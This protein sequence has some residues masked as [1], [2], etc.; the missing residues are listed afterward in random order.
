[1]KEKAEKVK[2]GKPGKPV[3]TMRRSNDVSK[4]CVGRR[5][6]GNVSKLYRG[7]ISGC[8][9]HVRVFEDGHLSGQEGNSRLALV[10]SQC[11]PSSIG[12]LITRR[13]HMGVC[14]DRDEWIDASGDSW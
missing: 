13:V 4:G 10:E 14:N 7:R 1:V 9:V 11:E 3:A 12:S 8:S 6:D 5:G 2:K